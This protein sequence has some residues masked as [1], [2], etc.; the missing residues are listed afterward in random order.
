MKEMTELKEALIDTLYRKARAIAYMDLPEDD[1]E[2]PE[3]KDIRKA[4]K[5]EEKRTKLF[6]KAFDQLSSWV[7]TTEKKY[8]LLHL[9]HLRRHGQEGEALQLINKM[10]AED[11][12]NLLLYK[13]RSDI[14]GELGWKFAEENEEQWRLLRKRD[15][16]LPN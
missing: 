10:I 15:E 16:F 2:H 14:Y 4:P 7:D 5:D 9:R 6:E 8:A 13:K 11:P 12:T 3:N 1:P